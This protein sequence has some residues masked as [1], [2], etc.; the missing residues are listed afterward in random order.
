MSKF[1][2]RVEIDGSRN[3]ITVHP[4]DG[5]H[6][7]TMFLMHGLGDTADGWLD[8]AEEIVSRFPYIK[9][10]LPTAESRSVTLNMG[11]RMPA[12]YDITGLSADRASEDCEGLPESMAIIKSL[13]ETENALGISYTRMILG[14]FSQGG[15]LTLSTGLQLPVD[16]KPAGLLVMSGYLPAASKF[17]LTPGLEDVPI[18]HTHGNVDP[19]VQYNWAIQTRNAIISRGIK[20][21]ELKTYDKLGHGINQ[22]LLEYA[23]QFI[24]KILIDDPS[25]ALKPKE[26]SEMSVKEL[27]IAIRNY[28]L[29]QQAL[30][31]SEKNEFVKL[32]E[33]YRASRS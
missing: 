22:E 10:V 14:G 25:L 30:G 33:E 28:N 16:K 21:Y 13:M 6:S 26:F 15:A 31:F 8:T 17:N 2:P 1:T 12:W 23:Q 4:F 29:G 3:L 19:V 5:K 24:S 7:A 20:N 9:V 27:K 18:L 11:A 32:L